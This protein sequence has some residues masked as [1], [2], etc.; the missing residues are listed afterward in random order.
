M[1][2]VGVTP[3]KEVITYCQ[4][5]IRASLTWFALNELLGRPA[6][7]YPASWEEWGNRPDLPVAISG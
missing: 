1:R 6:R 7:L 3:E 2:A 4:G 5:G